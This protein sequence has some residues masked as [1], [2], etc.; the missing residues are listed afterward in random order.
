MW[1]EAAIREIVDRETRARD[2]QDVDLL[3]SVFH[4]DMVWPWPRTYKSIDP[5]IGGSSWVAS[6]PIVGEPRTK[7]SSAGMS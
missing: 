1:D 2:T 4:A 6:T 7:T 5:S 3:L